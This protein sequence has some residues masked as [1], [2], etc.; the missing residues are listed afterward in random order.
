MYTK[1][2]VISTGTVP[3]H[4]LMKTLLKKTIN[5]KFC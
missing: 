3:N 2:Q 4:L 5:S 1:N